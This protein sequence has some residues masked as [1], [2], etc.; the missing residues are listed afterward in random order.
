MK[1]DYIISFT[2]CNLLKMSGY[3][4]V[5]LKIPSS[6]VPVFDYDFRHTIWNEIRKWLLYNMAKQLHLPMEFPDE[7]N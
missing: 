6:N 7:P 2:N 4:Y 3:I 1:V 5:E